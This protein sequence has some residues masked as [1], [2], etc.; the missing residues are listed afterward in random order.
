MARL[1]IRPKSTGKMPVGFKKYW[2]SKGITPKR[3]PSEDELLRVARRRATIR[4][5]RLF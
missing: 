4:R 1:P 5:K 2:G 3:P